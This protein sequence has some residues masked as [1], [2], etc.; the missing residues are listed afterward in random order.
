MTLSRA[1]KGGRKPGGGEG[2]KAAGNCAAASAQVQAGE[3]LPTLLLPRQLLLLH[4]QHARPSPVH[5]PA[6]LLECA[7]GP[8]QPSHRLM[9]RTLM[10]AV[11]TP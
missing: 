5:A 11:P 4:R 10:R 6:L 1:E 9:A 3:K 7:A 8:V 2:G